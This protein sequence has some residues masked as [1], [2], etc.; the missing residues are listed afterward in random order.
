[1]TWQLPTRPVSPTSG[2]RAWLPRLE[3]VAIHER[4][5]GVVLGE[6]GEPAR[7][8]FEDRHTNPHPTFDWDTRINRES[9]GREQV[10]TGCAVSAAA[11]PRR[12]MPSSDFMA[13][14]WERRELLGG[15]IVRP[16]DRRTPHQRDWDF[17]SEWLDLERNRAGIPS[18]ASP[19]DILALIATLASSRRGKVFPSRHPVDVAL[20]SSFCVGGG[21]L[22]AALCHVAGIP[23]RVIHT[24]THTMCEA[25]VDGRWCL[26]DSID[27]ATRQEWDRL[28]PD[29]AAREFF[30]DGLLRLAL[31]PSAM[32]PATPRGQ[33]A[34]YRENQPL[35]EPWIST[36]SRDWHFGQCSLG[37]DR[38]GDPILD[39]S[40]VMAQPGPSTVRAIYPEW[41]H[42][43]H[44]AIAG[45]QRELVLNPRQGWCQVAVPL[46]R[47][48]A[49]RQ[50]FWLGAFWLG[51]LG[52]E[53]P[54]HALRLDLFLVDSFGC[55]F[56]PSRGRWSL[57][58]NGAAVALDSDAWELRGDVLSF[59]V[60]I[61][62]LREQA[63]NEVV[64]SSSGRYVGFS[65]YRM[66]DVLYFW[67][68]PDVL[69][70]GEP[71][72]QTNG[73]NSFAGSFQTMLV[74][75][76]HTAYLVAPYAV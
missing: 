69:G 40:S 44:L 71:W 3:V 64:L 58:V 63:R 74:Q 27:P 41:E 49:L 30:R 35:T 61:R 65:D 10:I 59:H 51:A 60:P 5:D 72:L 42:P 22:G 45:R 11:L 4:P 50:R 8:F 9:P 28:D 24:A 21:G 67:S 6:S 17:L 23:A 31:D 68:Y 55:E 14:F 15:E 26:L 56:S 46:D 62:H 13:R 18:T 54:V 37:H 39:G 66:P 36:S 47:G 32:P 19:C 29:L 48:M 2:E 12:S 57:S 33:V 43:R 20:Y 76:N 34:R 73:G 53:N 7:F 38:T 75:G 52:G 25:R 70:I 16:S 1:M